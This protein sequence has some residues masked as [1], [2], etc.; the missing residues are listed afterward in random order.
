[1]LLHNDKKRDLILIWITSPMCLFSEA[2]SSGDGE[3]I[4]SCRKESD[5]LP[6]VYAR[7]WHSLSLGLPSLA[8]EL[9]QSPFPHPPLPTLT[10]IGALNR[11]QARQDYL[12]PLPSEGHWDV[13]ARPVLCECAWN[14]F[15]DVSVNVCDSP[16]ILLKDMQSLVSRWFSSS[17]CHWNRILE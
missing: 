10:H 3:M 12:G 8:G 4:M 13:G 11:W 1:M 6:G 15:K 16:W 7:L 2:V 5:G 9:P 14:M 17:N